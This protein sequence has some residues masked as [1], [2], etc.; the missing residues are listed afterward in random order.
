ME[1]RKNGLRPFSNMRNDGD[2]NFTRKN[3][4]QES[5]SCSQA[6]SRGKFG[7]TLF[8][9]FSLEGESDAISPFY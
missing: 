4:P 6:C 1:I 5:V 9:P 7:H 2:E 8:I 3:W